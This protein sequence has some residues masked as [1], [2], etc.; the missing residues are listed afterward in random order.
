MSKGE[1]PLVPDFIVEGGVGVG[2]HHQFLLVM[3]GA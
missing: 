1:V 3:G 2:R